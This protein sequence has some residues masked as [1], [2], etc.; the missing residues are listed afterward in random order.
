MIAY[1]ISFD[2]IRQQPALSSM[3]K[4]LERGL[5][6]F[7][8]DYYLVGAVSRDVWMSGLNNITPRRATGDIDFAVYIND[9]GVYESLKEYLI[10]TEGFKP[11]SGNAFVLRWKDG[12]E[13]DLLPFGA[14]EDENSRVTIQGTGYT[15]INV[16]GFKEVF[17]EGLPELELNEAHRFKFCTIPG[18]VLLK[19]ISWEDRPEVRRDDI[20]DICDLLYHFFDIYKEIIWQDHNDLF[21]NEE[22]DLINIAA[23]VL[24]KELRKITFR[25]EKLFRR[26]GQLLVEN[27]RNATESKI[28]AIMIEYF[29]NTLE[30]N[31][32]ML[33]QIRKGLET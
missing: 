5:F 7:N 18:L 23:C 4:A 28:A 3:L 10:N 26:I 16:D 25:N 19:L 15:S 20:K 2:Q 12:T 22:D 24:G 11:Y 29:N 6:R 33:K 13:M 27:T 1:K 14:I 30:D 32:K 17:E 9:K 21:K 8:I 31:V